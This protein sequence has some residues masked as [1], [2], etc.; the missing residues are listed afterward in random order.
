MITMTDAMMGKIIADMTIVVDTREKKNDHIL[1][2]LKEE[3]IPY[4][5]EKLDSAD[6]SFYL[7]TYPEIYADKKFLVEKKNSLDEIAQNFTKGRPRFE[8]EFERLEHGQKI[9]LLIENATWKKLY[10]GSY[11]SNIN[12]K[13]FSASLLTWCT[14]YSCP[15]WM[16]TPGESPMLIYQILHYELLEHLKQIRLDNKKK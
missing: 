3:N 10:N 16:C 6:Y 13:S 2:Y 11:R 5:I 1:K 15:V 8:R 12:P 4:I 7:P 9:H 14:R